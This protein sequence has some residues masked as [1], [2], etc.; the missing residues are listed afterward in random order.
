MTRGIQTLLRAINNTNINCNM[1]KQCDDVDDLYDG[2]ALVSLGDKSGYID[3][4]GQR[5]MYDKYDDGT[6]LAKGLLVCA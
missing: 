3:H 5:D 6:F 4:D 2:F 1:T